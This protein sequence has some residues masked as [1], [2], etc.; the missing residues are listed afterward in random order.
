[1]VLCTVDLIFSS[2]L[3]ISAVV[4]AVYIEFDSDFIWTH[5]AEPINIGKVPH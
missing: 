4:L 2:F 3:F 1:M 5:F